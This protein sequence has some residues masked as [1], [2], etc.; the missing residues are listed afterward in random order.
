MNVETWDRLLSAAREAREFAHAPYSKFTVGA[1]IESSDG[2]VFTGCNVECASLGLTV[3]AE[4][5]AGLAAVASGV[6][7]F[8]RLLV[9]ARVCSSVTPC[10]ACRQVL[11]E[12]AEELEIAVADPETIV[13]HFRLSELLPEPFDAG[14]LDDE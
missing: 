9:M 2:R 12:F 5:I 10:G 4:R 6:R 8:R 7:S 1:A 14:V 11:R 3:C 13:R